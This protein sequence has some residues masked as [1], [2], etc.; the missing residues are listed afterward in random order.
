MNRLPLLLALLALGCGS[1]P[2]P[3]PPLDDDPP[4]PGASLQMYLVLTADPAAMQDPAAVETMWQAV[5]GESERY[6]PIQSRVTGVPPGYELDIELDFAD[7]PHPALAPDALA[8]MIAELPPEARARAE[9]AKLAVSIRSTTDTL[10]D[11]GHIRLVGAAALLAADRHDGVI[12]DLL[13]RRAWTA[14]DWYA[15]LAA[16]TLSSRQIRLAQRRAQDGITLQ[17]RGNPKYG[18][19][20]LVMPAV[21]PPALDAARRRFIAVQ[22]RLIERGGAPGARV[23]V[24]GGEITLAPCADAG[25]VEVGCVQIPPPE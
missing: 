2:A 13:A 17:T 25:E 16:P 4:L 11:G 24:P 15:E 22:D 20:D 18:A 7:L 6:R 3:A 23:A 14:A 8:A 19:P 5:R 10:P 1:R 9:A 12:L 21:A